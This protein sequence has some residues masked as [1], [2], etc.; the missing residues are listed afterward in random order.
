MMCGWHLYYFG[1][2]LVMGKTKTKDGEPSHG[3]CKNCRRAFDKG[4]EPIA[5][6]YKETKKDERFAGVD[7]ELLGLVEEA[8]DFWSKWGFLN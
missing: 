3:I 2:E 4:Q 1:Q 5:R 7:E 6:P 8:Q